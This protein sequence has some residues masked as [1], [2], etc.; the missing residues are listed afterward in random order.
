MGGGRSQ[1]VL[2]PCSSVDHRLLPCPKSHTLLMP[3]PALPRQPTLRRGQH[4]VTGPT[5]F[6]S[7]R[8]WNASPGSEPD[9]LGPAR[10]LPRSHPQVASG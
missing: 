8:G 1:K 10:N 2:I 3:T 4:T 7:R 5:C 6:F 9:A